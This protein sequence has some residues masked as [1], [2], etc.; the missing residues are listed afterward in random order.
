MTNA[1]N[2]LARQHL[3]ESIV[4]ALLGAPLVPL[5]ELAEF[6]GA[7]VYAIY[8]SGPFQPYAPLARANQTN[9]GS[10]PIY[11]GQAEP[12]GGRKG[13]LLEDNP[14]TKKLFV[15]LNQHKK[16]IESAN[17]SLALADF[18]VR[19]LVLDS[20]WLGLAEAMLINRYNP[21]W[22]AVVEGFGNND[23]GG[24]RG[25]GRLPL[26]DSLHPGRSWAVGMDPPQF[27]KEKLLRRIE[28]HLTNT[29]H[30]WRA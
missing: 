5:A 26:W 16:T 17:K 14:K 23:P 13:G 29:A 6:D 22:N 30:L 4:S 20:I 3:A 11:A 24:K 9:P 12:E 1:F 18:S 10:A 19:W 15:R 25:K 21:L 7:G 27:D 8:Y 2:P 28:E